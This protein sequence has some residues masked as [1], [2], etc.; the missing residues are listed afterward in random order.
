MAILSRELRKTLEKVVAEA[1]EVAEEAA[2]KALKALA[3]GEAEAHGSMTA[4]QKALRN[5]LRAHGRQLGDWRNAEKG[6]QQLDRLIAECA[7]EHWHR[8][9]FARFLAE[10]QLLIEP[11]NDV[12][13]SI[14]EVKELAR[15]RGQDWVA[16]GGEFAVRMLPQVFRQ[17]D[18]VLGVEFAPEDRKRLEE[19]LESLPVGVFSADD[20]LGWTYQFWQAQAKDAIN[21]SGKK[22]GAD[23]LGPVTQFFTEDYMVEFLLHNTLGAW[24]AG[25]VLATNPALATSAASED[26]LRDA[27]AVGS[28]RWTYLR[29]VRQDGKPWRP[30][31]G[32]F[33]KWPKAARDITVLD[34]CMGSGHF[35][36]FALPIIAALRATE[37]GLAPKDAFSAALRD[38]LFGLELDARCTQIAAFN[39]ALAAWRVTGFKPIGALQLACSGVAPNVLEQEWTALSGKDE[40]LRAGMARLHALFKNAP[41]LGSLINPRADKGDLLVAEFHELQPLLEKAL[42]NQT[43]DDTAHEMAVTARG[44]AKAAELLADRFTLVATNVP[45]LGHTKHNDTLREFCANHHPAAKWD[46]YSAFMQRAH[47]WCGP[48]GS[49]A[50]VSPAEWTF[51]KP[52]LPFRSELL[53][54]QTI[55]LGAKLGFGSFVTPVRANPFLCVLTF[56][57]CLADWEFELV[58][59]S[60]ARELK[61]KWTA[62]KSRPFRRI[63]QLSQLRNP[64]SRIINSDQSATQGLLS[65]YATA[66]TGLSAGDSSMF[67]RLFWEV[68]EL[69]SVW[70]ATQ[71]SVRATNDF[72][73]RSGIVRWENETGLMAQ[74][75]ESV[76]HL[77]HAA[78]NWRR[79]KPAWGKEGVAI[80]LMGNLPTTR[81]GGQ[82]YDINC[83]AIIPKDPADLAVLWAFAQSGELAR[84]IRE[85]DQSLKLAPHTLLKVPFDPTHW[86]KV[87]A[88]KY[89]HGLPKPFSSDPTQWLFSGQPK[90]A[91]Q[92]LQVAVARL[93]GYQW[94][95]QT[96]SSFPDCPALEPGGL[97]THADT[98]GI[99][100]LASLKGEE[101]AGERLRKLMATACGK[102][103]SAAKQAELLAQV[104]FAGNSLDDWLRDGFFEQHCDLFHQRPFVWH[105]WDGERDGFH[106]L[107][108]YHKL[109]APNGA[110]GKALEKLTFAYLGDWIGRQR[111][112]QKQGKEGADTK[113]AAAL[114]LQGELKK[115]LDGEPPYDLFV[116]WKPL[117]EQAIGWE[118]DL[119]DG[120]RMNIRPFMMAETLKGKSIFRKAPKIKWDKDR[121]KEPRRPK[122]D[123]PW[124]WGWDE[125]KEDF[126][127]GLDFDGN[128]WN[129]LHYS[130]AMKNEARARHTEKGR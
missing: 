81:Y 54:K 73:G 125:A 78:Q 75:A 124:F 92:P 51:L 96:G 34:P 6:T 127:G 74:L 52:F 55:V 61:S 25:K 36:V 27:C 59:V 72:D 76:R 99:V 65:E 63:H 53:R 66:L 107:V 11:A 82:K 64:D 50:V 86:R 104:Q 105:I 46:L 109:A 70:E 1:R 117:H 2:K 97:D 58:D 10:N 103:W 119:N 118:P 93:V 43:N 56:V 19:L 26:E 13:I 41:V 123:F 110:G 114:H 67:D 122:P 31:A 87:A 100:C 39:L 24:W 57:P 85:I 101:A 45:Y 83:C 29:F 108:N 111:A 5:R 49:L 17:D 37:E 20:S 3:V 71:T 35:L 129:D 88:E 12:A 90:G 30:A 116:R 113:V 102:E 9:L 62:L 4:E 23:E 112:E 21:A 18:P 89:P 130:I 120:V 14:E 22:I 121:G 91:D 7:Y 115:I 80:S 128:R 16:L 84:A 48:A 95:R 68:P 94:P 32:A 79:G 126:K 69:G 33:E 60:D 40:R 8:M 98:D 28:V 42:A 15:K 38:N 47:H 106:A 44:L 77:N